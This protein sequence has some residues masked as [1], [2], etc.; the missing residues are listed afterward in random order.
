VHKK[1]I[2]AAF[3]VALPVGVMAQTPAPAQSPAQSLCAEPVVPTV[4]DGKTATVDQMRAVMADA[5]NFIAQSDVY[6]NCLT[7]EAEA[8]NMQA[9]T[10]KKP[11]DPAI[12]DGVKAKVM[13]SQKMKEKVGA[14]ANAAIDAY[15]KA[16][17]K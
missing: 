16:H 17:P 14:A 4:V 8:T 5:R 13:A 7:N 1:I 10:D 6:Q 2:L 3:F 11:A 15:K 12:E 9:A